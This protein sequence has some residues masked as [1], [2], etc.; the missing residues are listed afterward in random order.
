[1][2]W[3]E[4]VNVA[5]T[6]LTLLVGFL[7]PAVVAFVTKRWADS[8]YKAIV[9]LFLSVI[10]GWL[11]ELQANG[12]TFKLW[13]TVVNILV[14]FATAVISHFGL[15]QPTHVTGSDGIIQLSVP[16]GIGTERRNVAA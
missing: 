11:T 4:T 12:G 10:A 7:L 16:G 5:P 14:T 6:V 15:L 3:D 9:L 2:N 8:W 13:P 1:M